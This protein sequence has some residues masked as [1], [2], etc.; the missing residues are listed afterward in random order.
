MQTPPINKL[1]SIPFQWEEAPGKP[2]EIFTT[3][4]YPKP[5]YHKTPAARCLDLPPRLINN[6]KTSPTTVLDGPF[7]CSGQSS[8]GT[9]SYCMLKGYSSLSLVEEMR[10]E[11][12]DDEKKWDLKENGRLKFGSS[13]WSWGSFKGSGMGYRSAS[14]R[15]HKSAVKFSKVKRRSSFFR[16]SQ[17]S[18]NLWAGVYGSLKQVAPWRW[19]HQ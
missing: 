1:A 5:P 8:S 16:I 14:V 4:P 10:R 18:S 19:R 6:V 13:S 7:S 12:R 3:N 2:R 15:S 11:G 9:P 17:A